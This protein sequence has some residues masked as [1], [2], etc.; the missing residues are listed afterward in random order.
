MDALLASHNIIPDQASRR[1]LIERVHIALDQAAAKLQRN[2]DGDFSPDDNVKRFPPLQPTETHRALVSE[3]RILDIF[4]GWER[5]ALATNRTEKTVS[6]YRATLERLI[7]FLSHDDA[8]RVTPA[9]IVAYKDMRLSTINELTGSPISPK[10]VGDGD[11]T[12]LKSV[13][14]WAAKNHFISSNP[15]KGIAIK[16]GEEIRTRGKG[17]TDA[18]AILLLKQEI[19]RAH[20]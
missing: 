7:K 2:A 13:F 14:G 4:K 6:E 12:A 16:L 9:D 3:K 11:L 20:V 15:A 19:G 18:E 8:A 1:R 5:E 17:Y 10:T